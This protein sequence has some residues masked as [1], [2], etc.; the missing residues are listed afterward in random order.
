[1][2]S[3]GKERAGG[4]RRSKRRMKRRKR[5]KS[6]SKIKRRIGGCGPCARGRHGAWK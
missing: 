5:I 6:K 4:G 2:A 3:A 1:V